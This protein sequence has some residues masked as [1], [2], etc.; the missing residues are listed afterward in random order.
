[1]IQSGRDAM[2][3]VWSNSDPQRLAN[4]RAH[5]ANLIAPAVA[6]EDAMGHFATK[7]GTQAAQ[8][9]SVWDPL[10]K[11]FGTT[12]PDMTRWLSHNSKLLLW[13][14]S[15]TL[16][17]Q[18]I[19]ENEKEG[20]S[21]EQAIEDAG[22]FISTYR[23]QPTLFGTRS[24]YDRAAQQML[25]DNAT[26]FFGRYHAGLAWN[27]YGHVFRNLATGTPAQK[28]EA[29]GQLI[30][31]AAITGVMYPVL[32]K[33]YQ[34]ATGNENASVG[35]RGFSTIPQGLYEAA[36][37][38]N[39]TKISGNVWTPSI[40]IKMGMGAVNNTDPFT[41]KENSPARAWRWTQRRTRS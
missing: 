8:A 34:K 7:L 4:Y 15:D 6:N 28:K 26:S 14:M 29:L 32:D 41:G 27:T 23:V 5:G 11:R 9:P 38:A 19:I 3:L 36:T 39:P 2:E 35:R 17:L 12:V 10:T 20:M 18:R 1:M 31:G 22:H 40:P 33:L 24:H 25:V 21:I 37:E 13:K 16:Y 30:V